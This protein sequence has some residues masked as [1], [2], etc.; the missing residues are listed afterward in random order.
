MPGDPDATVPWWRAPDGG[1]N[2]TEMRAEV[3]QV[4]DETLV[5]NRSFT[6]ALGAE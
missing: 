3:E 6:L 5:E 2:R 1:G 4:V